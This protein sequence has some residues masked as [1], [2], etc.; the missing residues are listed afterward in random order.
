MRTQSINWSS[1]QT[2]SNP[3][4]QR[5]QGIRKPD[6]AEVRQAVTSAIET[7]TQ[8]V[9]RASIATFVVVGILVAAIWAADS[10]AATGIIQ[11]M[12]WASSVVFLALAVEAKA[13]SFK[14]LL[15]TGLGLGVLALLGSPQN[16]EFIIIAAVLIAAWSAWAILQGWKE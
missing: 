2:S 8:H 4:S 12:I 11:A 7:A 1:N 3:I 13:S 10:L 9:V 15:A 6:P 16:F 14:P 5:L